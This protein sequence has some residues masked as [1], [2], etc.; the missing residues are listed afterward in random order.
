MSWRSSL[1]SDELH[2]HTRSGVGQFQSS[3]SGVKEDSGTHNSPGPQQTQVI[4]HFE[5]L[6][7]C[8]VDAEENAG[9]QMNL[10]IGHSGCGKIIEFYF[11]LM[12]SSKGALVRADG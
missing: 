8:N 11:P 2:G 10:N 9:R 1:W 4:T 5:S 7:H 12:R 3:Q 6:K